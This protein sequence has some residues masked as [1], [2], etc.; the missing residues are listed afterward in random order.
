M[1]KFI[2]D[3]P[4][5]L[6]GNVSIHGAKNA[7]LPLMAAALLARGKSVISNVPELRDVATMVKML[8]LLGART[9]HE[10]GVLTIDST[11]ANG[12]EAPYDL[13][14]TMRASIYV[15][16]PTLAVHGRA[17]VSMPGGCAWGPR[18]IDLHLMAMEKLGAKIELEH[19][20]IEASC[21]RLR[22]AEILFPISSVGA[23]AQTVMAASLAEGST[24]IE[25]AALEPEITDLV[26]AL[27]ECGVEI[28]GA[29]TARLVIHGTTSVRPLVHRVI[30]DRIEAETFAGAAAVTGGDVTITDCDPGHMGAV[31]ATLESCGCRV[32]TGPGRVRVVGPKRLAATD[33]VTREYPGFPTDMQAQIIAVLCRAD[34]VSTVKETIYPDRFTHVPELRRFGADIRLD[35]N[36]A[37]IRG[38]PSLQGAPVMATDIRASSGLI[39]AAM[40]A[41]GRSE[42]LRVYHIDRGYQRIELKL[43]ALGARIERATQ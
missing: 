39:L 23:T 19:G 12:I 11:D 30:A 3:G 15:L 24:V 20:Y 36:L 14:R 42:I 17:R 27:Q 34:G 10:N 38:V 28:E 4:T 9:V 5:P 35:G 16:A 22:G 33:V 43:R 40:A 21:D 29:G 8:D 13:V 26:H 7:V 37:V 31:L 18:P 6:H 1:D 32:E 25:N 41:E 2:V